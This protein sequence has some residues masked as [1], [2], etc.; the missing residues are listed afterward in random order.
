MS[1]KDHI[2]VKNIECGIAKGQTE[3]VSG[4]K[5]RVRLQNTDCRSLEVH[6]IKYEWIGPELPG[7]QFNE[8]DSELENRDDNVNVPP[9]NGSYDDI[10]ACKAV[11]SGLVDLRRS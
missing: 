3:M 1:G 6:G 7:H 11:D 8:I 2:G 5:S 4:I 10:S 9:N